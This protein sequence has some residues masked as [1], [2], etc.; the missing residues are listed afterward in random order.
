MEQIEVEILGLTITH[1]YGVL[2]TGDILRTN[3]EFARH[4]VED[5]CA[6]KYTQAQPAK[7]ELSAPAGKAGAAKSRKAA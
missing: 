1:Q 6:A 4:L 5:A 3:A 2:N 7:P